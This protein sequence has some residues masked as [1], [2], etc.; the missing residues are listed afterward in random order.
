MA[1]DI[2]LYT[3][4][5]D[6]YGVLLRDAAS[7]RVASV[8]AGDAPA[9]LGALDTTGWSLDELWI[10]HWHWDH[11]DGL[12]EVR[13]ATGCTV[14]GPAY[15]GGKAFA[16]DRRV[17][18]GD[19]FTLGETQ[20]D[21]WHTPGH[22]LDMVNFYLS[23]EG[24][25]FTGDTLFAMGC[26]RV[27]EGTHDQMHASMEMLRALPP[28]T[29]VYGGHEYTLANARFALSVD[30][31]NAALVARAAMVGRLRDEGAPTMPTTMADEFATNPFLRYGDPGIR[32]HLGMTS[33]SDAEV[34]S[35]IR[36]LKDTF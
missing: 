31:E 3:Y 29:V 32:A 7:G 28:E 9:L 16:F 33:A 10:T 26:G 13:G 22:T 12:D 35:Q 11:T 8:D 4:L 36:T 18:G 21:V 24:V 20:V 17:A 6:N 27:F 1:V 15:E 25:I 23:S 5:E 34:F 19:A 2:H 30:P 14:T